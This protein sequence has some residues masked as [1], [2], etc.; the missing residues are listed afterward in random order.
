MRRHDFLRVRYRFVR[1]L[2]TVAEV[3]YDFVGNLY[4]FAHGVE[5]DAYDSEN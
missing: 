4:C 5:H 1:V 3:R 2:H